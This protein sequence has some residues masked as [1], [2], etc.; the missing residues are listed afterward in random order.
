M[1]IFSRAVLLT[2]ACCAVSVVVAQSD[3]APGKTIPNPERQRTETLPANT[4]RESRRPLETSAGNPE[5]VQHPGST[6]IVDNALSS[7]VLEPGQLERIK[8]MDER[9][10]T[11]L[12]T[13]GPVKPGELAYRMLWQRRERE[14]ADILTP[15]QFERW[16][17]L[18]RSMA[19]AQPTPVPM[20]EA[21]VEDKALTP[22]PEAQIDSTHDPMPQLDSIPP[23]SPPPPLPQ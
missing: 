1:N 21:N 13:M 7:L 18:N 19:Q 8:R 10:A 6:S 3:P 17:E 12:K 4:E 23:A 9:Y 22:L 20:P 14:I 2:A 5:G 11:E 15:V 16:K